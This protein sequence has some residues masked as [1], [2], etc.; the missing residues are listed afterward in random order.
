MLILPRSNKEYQSVN[1]AGIFFC[2][3]QKNDTQRLCIPSA[4]IRDEK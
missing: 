2:L 4:S 3:I 1:Q